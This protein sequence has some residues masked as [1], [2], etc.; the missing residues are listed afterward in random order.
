MAHL[1][2]KMELLRLELGRP[3]I[4]RH[5]NVRRPNHAA[6]GLRDFRR[7]KEAVRPARVVLALV[8]VGEIAV[9][10]LD[11]VERGEILGADGAEFGDHGEGSVVVVLETTR[12]LVEGLV[13]HEGILEDVGDVLARRGVAVSAHADKPVRH[14]SERGRASAGDDDVVATHEF[15]Q[16]SAHDQLAVEFGARGVSRQVSLLPAVGDV[17]EI[18]AGFEG[19]FP[20]LEVALLEGGHSVTGNVAQGWKCEVEHR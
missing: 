3:P 10:E 12:V 15:G 5:L 1:P 19:G 2:P 4:E 9:F 17:D 11:E 6:L 16:H 13:D 14:R 18:A 7:Q 20:V 8:A